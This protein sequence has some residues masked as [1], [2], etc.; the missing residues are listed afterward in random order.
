[1]NASKQQVQELDTEHKL[2]QK[3]KS[4]CVYINKE[5]LSTEDTPLLQPC[6][7][8]VFRSI[9]NINEEADSRQNEA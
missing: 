1:M 5:K 8:K 2:M 9:C 3:I 4:F 6:V 7:D